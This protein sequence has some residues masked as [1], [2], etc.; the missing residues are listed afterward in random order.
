MD[1]IQRTVKM[2]SLLCMT[3]DIDDDMVVPLDDD[4]VVPLFCLLSCGT[5]QT[6][7]IMIYGAQQEGFLL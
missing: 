7:F 1:S 3:E 6:R 4:M 5:T 2:C